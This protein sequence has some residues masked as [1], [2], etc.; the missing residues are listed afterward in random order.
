MALTGINATHGGK[1]YSMKRIIINTVFFL[2]AI[3]F[4]A[5]ILSSIIVLE[6]GGLR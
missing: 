5:V 1:S 2:Y 4:A 6:P 3:G